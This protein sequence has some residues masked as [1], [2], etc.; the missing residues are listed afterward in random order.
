MPEGR[1][2]IR[3]TQGFQPAFLC[4]QIA[5]GARPGFARRSDV[6]C[7]IAYLSCFEDGHVRSL[8]SSED[9][10]S[11]EAEGLRVGLAVHAGERTFAPPHMDATPHLAWTLAKDPRSSAAAFARAREALRRLRFGIEPARG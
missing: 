4:L 3:Y 8:P 5:L 11:I 2:E 9:L 7:A 1:A 6:R 10:A